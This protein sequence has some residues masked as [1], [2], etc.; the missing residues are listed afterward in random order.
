MDE[1]LIVNEVVELKKRSKRECVTFKV[2]YEKG[3]D[4]VD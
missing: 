1:V 4:S 2:D 3:Y